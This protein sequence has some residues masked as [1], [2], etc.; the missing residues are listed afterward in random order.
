MSII[1]LEE[2]A[3]KTKV[4]KIPVAK[5]PAEL[6]SVIF[7]TTHVFVGPM[8]S[9]TAVKGA[10]N[11]DNVD[12]HRSVK[13]TLTNFESL[14]TALILRRKSIEFRGRANAPNQQDATMTA[15]QLSNC[16]PDGTSG[17]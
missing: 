11:A 6:K 2:I 7:T 10:T 15:W 8:C 5:K 9:A 16:A 3:R 13:T 12:N 4:S 1:V 17:V 14:K